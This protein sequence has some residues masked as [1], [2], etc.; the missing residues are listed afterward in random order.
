[1]HSL[2]A[3]MRLKI[4]ACTVSGAF[5]ANISTHKSSEHHILK[6]VCNMTFSVNKS[7]HEQRTPKCSTDFATQN[8][9]ERVAVSSVGRFVLISPTIQ[10][11]QKVSFL[12]S[13]YALDL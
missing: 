3:I 12:H 5:S 9:T 2:I 13:K 7:K 4:T 1:M 10:V 11:R 8:L 6:Y